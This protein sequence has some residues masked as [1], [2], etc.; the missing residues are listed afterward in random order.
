MVLDITMFGQEV[1]MDLWRI[2]KTVL[3][4]FIIKPIGGLIGINAQESVDMEIMVCT[5][6]NT[7]RN[8]KST[9]AIYYQ[10]IKYD[11]IGKFYNLHSPNK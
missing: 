1:Q 5:A 10:G 7:L 8:T 6:N 11:D 4:K 9:L 3:K 2:L